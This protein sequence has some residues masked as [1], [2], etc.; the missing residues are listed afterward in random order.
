M[1]IEWHDHKSKEA[2]KVHLAALRN[3][4]KVRETFVLHQ[5]NAPRLSHLVR[6]LKSDSYGPVV[7]KRNSGCNID[8]SWYCADII[9]DGVVLACIDLDRNTVKWPDYTFQMHIHL[10]Y[11][12]QEAYN[13]EC[14][15]AEKVLQVEV[16]AAAREQ[17][18]EGFKLVE[19][20]DSLDKPHP[21]H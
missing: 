16:L 11:L 20:I 6:Y 21:V 12:L 19:M 3:K 7:L 10:M 17:F 14:L 18:E 9:Y 1:A 5:Q 13:K 15:E 4:H 8:F 2:V